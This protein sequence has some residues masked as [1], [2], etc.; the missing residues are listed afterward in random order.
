MDDSTKALENALSA[1]KTAFKHKLDNYHPPS[2]SDIPVLDD[3][4]TTPAPVQPVSNPIDSVPEPQPP[5]H[6]PNTPTP[7]PQTR[8][9]NN[10]KPQNPQGKSPF[11]DIPKEDKP[12]AEP[13]TQPYLSVPN[14]DSVNPISPPPLAPELPF[15]PIRIKPRHI[16]HRIIT[17]INIR[18]GLGLILLLLL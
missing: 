5:I 3:P 17:S 10:E 11:L 13:V 12:R 1:Y 4:T 16:A 7:K 6:R 14:N 2:T 9:T 15:T 8:P 18:I